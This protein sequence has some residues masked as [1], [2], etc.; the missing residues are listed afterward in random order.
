MALL[1]GQGYCRC[2]IRRHVRGVC[3][4]ASWARTQG[5]RFTSWIRTHCVD[6]A[7]S[8]RKLRASL[9]GYYL[10]EVAEARKIASSDLGQSPLSILVRFPYEPICKASH[11]GSVATGPPTQGG[12]RLGCQAIQE[13]NIPRSQAQKCGPPRRSVGVARHPV[14]RDFNLASASPGSCG[15]A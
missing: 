14:R 5:L 3:Y 15:T 6:C 2:T 12:H 13:S 9:H 4:F 10:C 11:I 7:A 1:D 8:R